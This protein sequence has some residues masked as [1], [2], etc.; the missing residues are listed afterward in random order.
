MRILADTNVF[1]KYWKNKGDSDLEIIKTIEN[2]DI[3]V[4]GVIR[5]ELLHG[6]RTEKEMNRYI[7]LLSAFDELE[8]N[9]TDWD[10]VGGNLR[11]MRI[12]GL[13]VPFADAII[14]TMGL[15]YGVSIWS[16]DQHFQKIKEIMPD[17]KLYELGAPIKT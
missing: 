6:A 8:M 17:L 13:N 16:Y 1:I 11:E 7:N 9:E 10:T 5:A 4:C 14:A 12:N 2:E 15:K 3:V